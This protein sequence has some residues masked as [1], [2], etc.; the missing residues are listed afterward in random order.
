MGPRAVTILEENLGNYLEQIKHK[1]SENSKAIYFASFLQKVFDISPDEF[2]WEKSVKTEVMQL[3]GRIDAVFGDLIFEFKK[4]L[5]F[6]IETAKNELKKYFQSLYEKNKSYNYLGIA[7][8]GIK[9][10]V[11]RPIINNNI[12]EK[13]EEIDNSNL[14]QLSP[15][16]IF[17][18]F[19]SYLFRSTKLIPTTDDIKR[20]FG[21]QSPTFK[22]ILEK[23][24]ILYEKSKLRYKP[25]QIKYESWNRYL[26]IV[27]G[28]RPDELKLFLIHT[29][30]SSIVKI[31]VHIK[32]SQGRNLTFDDANPILY[33]SSFTK[34]GIVNFIEEDFFAW[35]LS[36]PIA[37]SSGEIFN[38]LLRELQVYDFEKIDEDILKELYQELILPEMRQ[39][40][41]EFYT[42]DWL[43]E[44]MIDECLK[45]NPQLR[46]MDP[47]CGSG[48][49]LFKSIQYKIEK[50][51]E[52]CWEPK[53][54]LEHILD[55][56]IGFDIHPLAVIVARTNYLLALKDLIKYKEHGITIPVYLSDSLKIPEK[57]IDLVTSI[58][59][60][61]Y[62]I[63]SMNK[64]FHI[65]ISIASQNSK[66]DEIIERMRRLGRELEDKIESVSNS[67]YP[68][69]VEVYCQNIINGFDKSL[70]K[71]Y[72]YE[73]RKILKDDLQILFDL[74]KDGKD[75]IWP[76]V[77]RNMYKPIAVSYNKV[78]LLIGNPPWLGFNNMK[79]EDYQ[80]YLRVRS[81]H[82][83]LIDSKKT[84][85]ISNLNLATLFFCQC[86]DQYLNDGGKIAFVMP[87]GVLFASQHVNFLKFEKIPINLTQ[88]YDLEHVI[89]LFRILSCVLFGTKGAKIK[90]PVP[91]Y[92]ISGKLSKNNALLHEALPTLT[93]E[94]SSYAPAERPKY[95]SFYY[96]KFSQG[97]QIIPRCFW[98]VDIKSDS[99]LGF[100]PETPTIES[101]ENR[102]A[103]IPWNI[104]LQGNIERPFFSTSL[105]SKDIVPFGYVKRRIIVVPLLMEEN[106]LKLLED[107]KQQEIV[108]TSFSQ[109]LE[110][111]ESLWLKLAP[112]KSKK[113][114]TI[115]DRI[116]FD[117]D[118]STQKPKTGFTVLYVKSATNLASCVVINSEKCTFSV[119]DNNF[120]I[121]GFF[122]E[123]TTYFFNTDSKDE[124]YYLCSVFNS[125][126]L[127]Q[128]IKPQQSRGQFGGARD[129]H[130]IPFTF[131]IEKYDSKNILHKELAE[132][133]I[134]CNF[135]V[136]KIL[137]TLKS[138]RS[139]T[140]REKIRLEIKNELRRIDEIM[141]SIL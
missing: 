107:S 50:L 117:N 49:F 2:D 55:S 76:Y 43:A 112:A 40:L 13:I 140:L 118:L 72:D 3:H 37:S 5:D 39:M 130:K 129:I 38:K 20:K 86:V 100:N 59:S 91:S 77:L 137:P 138:T 62:K 16:E 83:G 30:L 92:K 99:F 51:T 24:E 60:F 134:S 84:R 44:K 21:L 69:D 48:T 110:E 82:Y 120:E 54:I 31:I 7:T 41:G 6:D 56:V 29:Y 45:D 126:I 131:N 93:F 79:N 80:E 26:E 70:E 122:A 119:G 19:D 75:A 66:M 36:P 128:K 89:P 9:F 67:S 15:I 123:G 87:Q 12:I 116:D 10:H 121:K 132:L 124:A 133:G 105:L 23:L 17:S 125:Q 78:D 108:G 90:Y 68:F 47:S 18:W 111:A 96:D 61:E 53:K 104:K 103:K 85:N 11:F 106:N 102:D 57:N 73:E 115:Y 32:I 58:P 42:P 81:K 34:F 1:T 139:A 25:T 141:I 28:K 88:I 98:F 136:N 22:I 94:K 97:A 127:N 14:E 8:D 65:P 35:I 113:N 101:S 95:Q 109:Y 135:K 71:I 4:N 52:K 63:P 27:F 64:K 33:G 114:M 74:I 46:L